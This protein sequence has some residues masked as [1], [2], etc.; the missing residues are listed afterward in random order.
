MINAR[1]IISTS[2]GALAFTP[3]GHGGLQLSRLRF[4]YGYVCWLLSA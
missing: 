2:L 1:L 4:A 3:D